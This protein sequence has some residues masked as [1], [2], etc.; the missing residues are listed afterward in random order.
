MELKDPLIKANPLFSCVC[1]HVKCEYVSL[2]F[3]MRGHFD[4]TDLYVSLQ[5]SFHDASSFPGKLHQC[6]GI[7]S[8][9]EKCPAKGYASISRCGNTERISP[10]EIWSLLFAIL[11]QILIFNT[12]KWCI[13]D[14]L[15]LG[16]SSLASRR[17]PWAA[18]RHGN[19]WLRATT[20]R[21]SHLSRIWVGAYPKEA[22]ISVQRAGL[23]PA[24]QFKN[25]QDLLNVFLSV[26][27]SDKHTEP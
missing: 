15:T 4:L 19:R 12:G 17:E 26:F 24:Q 1:F 16:L 11:I 22:F 10:Y 6:L 5:H 14:I 20:H 21:S 7:V 8:V 25:A 23:V 9:Q 27:C 18:E 13:P 3:L 2:G